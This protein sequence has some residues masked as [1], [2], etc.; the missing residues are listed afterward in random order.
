MMLLPL[1]IIVHNY[2]LLFPYD[3]GNSAVKSHKYMD[4]YQDLENVNMKEIQDEYFR[5]LDIIK[6]N[7]YR[8][9]FI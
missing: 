4:R 9:E 6:E 7:F 3:F 2:F 1:H 5:Y 8:E